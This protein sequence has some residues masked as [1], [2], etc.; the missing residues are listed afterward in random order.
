MRSYL[1][2]A[3]RSLVRATAGMSPVETALAAGGRLSVEEVAQASGLDAETARC[4]LDGLVEAGEAHKA[5]DLA[6]RLTVYWTSGDMRP[7]A[8]AGNEP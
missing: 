8:E 7:D 2:L 3:K 6:R 1:E 4:E 5:V